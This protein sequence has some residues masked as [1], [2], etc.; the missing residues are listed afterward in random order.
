MN[1]DQK[2]STA[3]GN[4][5]GYQ[6]PLIFLPLRFLN[7]T[8]CCYFLKYHRHIYSAKNRDIRSRF[9]KSYFTLNDKFKKQ[10]IFLLSVKLSKEKDYS[11]YN[12]SE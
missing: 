8:R 4:S 1:S 6:A 10:I 7:L 3:E 2:H 9:S 12:Y 5:K 11:K